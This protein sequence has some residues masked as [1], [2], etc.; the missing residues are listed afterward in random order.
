MFAPLDKHGK[1]PEHFSQAEIEDA[2]AIPYP[3]DHH[4]FPYHVNGWSNSP[5]MNYGG[6]RVLRAEDGRLAYDLLCYDLD[7]PDHGKG[8][9]RQAIEVWQAGTLGRLKRE[10]PEYY[11]TC[12]SYTTRV[13]L[14]LLWTLPGVDASRYVGLWHATREKIQAVGISVDDTSDFGRCYRMPHAT[15]DGVQLPSVVD[16]SRLDE[17]PDLSAQSM[18]PLN[19]RLEVDG[20]IVVKDL[21]TRIS[22]GDKNNEIMKLLGFCRR[23]GANST[24]MRAVLGL[25]LRADLIEDGDQIAG[26]WITDAVRSMA[27]KPP[28]AKVGREYIRWSETE[29]GHIVRRCAAALG[30]AGIVLQRAARLIRVAHNDEGTL[31]LRE[32]HKHTLRVMIPEVVELT[33][34]KKAAEY[35]IGAPDKLVD[36][37]WSSPMTWDNVPVVKGISQCPVLRRDGSVWDTPGYDSVS[38]WYYD[39][40]VAVYPKGPERPTI[41]DAIAATSLVWEHVLKDY[42]FVKPEH[43]SVALAIPLT[44]LGRSLFDGPSP[45]FLVD[46]STRGS[47]KTLLIKSWSL[48]VSGRSVPIAGLADGPETDKRITAYLVKA[49]PMV[50]F[51]DVKTALGAE[52]VLDRLITAD[53]WSS[54]I[55]GQTRNVDLPNKIVWCASGNNVPVG[56]DMERRTL[57]CNIDPGVADPAARVGMPDLEALIPRVR[58]Q[59]VVALQTI[60]RAYILAGC[61]KA[62]LQGYGS[63]EGWSLIRQAIVWVG[64]PDPVL[65]RAE[66]AD[67]AD[68]TGNAVS[69]F[70]S[71]F[72]SIYGNGWQTVRD[73]MWTVARSKS[74]EEL[75]LKD[76]LTAMGAYND[77]GETNAVRLGRALSKIAGRRFGNLVFQRKMKRGKPFFR[78][79]SG[80]A[81]LV[82]EIKSA[83]P[84]LL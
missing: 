48:V 50:L 1:P 46:S 9:D 39:P 68:L 17:L 22:N 32:I 47:G 41:A 57:L 81:D 33:K 80:N 84:P 72:S 62:K 60:L 78:A 5:R 4:F 82:V 69:M 64:L 31:L 36:V 45:L 20:P 12:G 14:R 40:G 66:V 55:L 83:S 43:A 75:D 51:D 63:F 18:D 7:P 25:Y 74:A 30:K 59:L 65:T 44:V 58:P 29:L 71:V 52:G 6:L 76:A 61:P 27:S 23:H 73:I 35:E 56:A 77:R 79:V 19:K 67:K 21:P 34:V 11:A 2:L 37:L 70:L 24:L 8:W 42:R 53:V 16:L 54:R 49:V 10:L 3:G 26:T 38:G 13:G 15:R 28:A